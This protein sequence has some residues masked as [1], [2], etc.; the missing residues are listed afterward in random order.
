MEI[1]GHRCGFIWQERG[2]E[3]SGVDKGVGMGIKGA[4]VC[5]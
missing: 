4:E 1:W 3:R 5:G 2:K